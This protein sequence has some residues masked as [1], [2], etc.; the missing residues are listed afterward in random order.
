MHGY[1]LISHFIYRHES[2]LTDLSVL[3]LPLFKEP[4]YILNYI[5]DD[6]LC[7]ITF[8][9]HLQRMISLLS[10]SVIISNSEVERQVTYLIQMLWGL[11]Q[12]SNHSIKQR[13]A[14]LVANKPHLTAITLKAMCSYLESGG[15]ILPK[16]YK[17]MHDLT[18]QRMEPPLF[19]LPKSK[20][21]LPPPPIL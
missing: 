12:R 9:V 21:C 6:R 1:V 10:D 18:Y 13:M 20:G 5:S 14:H 11:F 7:E 19:F 3:E 8:S 15:N 2:I 4:P 16:L 17:C